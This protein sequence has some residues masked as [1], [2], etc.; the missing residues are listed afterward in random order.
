MH[1]PL[2][3]LLTSKRDPCWLT[4]HLFMQLGD[5]EKFDQFERKDSRR[6]HQ[7]L[8]AQARRDRKSQDPDGPLSPQTLTLLIIGF[9]LF[10]A[11]A[12]YLIVTLLLPATRS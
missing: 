4:M 9:V 7:A 2:K 12:A 11:S 5:R 1:D 8:K 3:H 6:S 10:I